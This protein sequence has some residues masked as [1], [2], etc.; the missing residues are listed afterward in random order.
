M[1]VYQID[2]WLFYHPSKTRDFRRSTPLRFKHH[3]S[4]WM[5]G[6]MIDMDFREQKVPGAKL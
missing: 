6:D 4:A 2:F 3:G 5:L 1:L